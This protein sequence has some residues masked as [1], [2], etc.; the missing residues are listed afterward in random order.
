MIKKHVPVSDL[1]LSD[2]ILDETVHRHMIIKAALETSVAR[3]P[4][5]R[6]WIQCCCLAAQASLH[7]VCMTQ[8]HKICLWVKVFVVYSLSAKQM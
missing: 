7:Y 4:W 6:A 5:V 8:V 1:F 2:L 3:L